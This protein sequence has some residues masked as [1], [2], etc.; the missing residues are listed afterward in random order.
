MDL[1]S[2]S[3]DAAAPTADDPLQGFS[4]DDDDD[5]DDEDDM[6]DLPPLDGDDDEGESAMEMVD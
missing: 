1:P 5:D 6:E 3:T 4:I 2:A